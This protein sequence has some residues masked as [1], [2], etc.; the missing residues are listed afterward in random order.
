MSLFSTS[1]AGLLHLT[2]PFAFI[3]EKVFAAA[4]SLYELTI[5]HLFGRD[6]MPR[7][8]VNQSSSNRPLSSVRLGNIARPSS[9]R[10]N[11]L[12][13]FH[14]PCVST[15][16]QN[17]HHTSPC[18]PNDVDS[19]ASLCKVLCRLSLQPYRAA[20]RRWDTR[21]PLVEISRSRVFLPCLVSLLGWPSTTG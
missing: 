9:R 2:C 10:R 19:R 15:N 18:R 4:G 5:A 6:P 17:G 13:L 21:F 16:P 1:G 3:F 12:M 8:T 14:V 20:C 7:T 11:H